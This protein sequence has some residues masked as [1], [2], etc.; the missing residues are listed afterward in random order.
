MATVRTPIPPP[1]RDVWRA[2]RVARYARALELRGSGFTYQR[3]GM[4]LGV[5]AARAQQMF[6]VGLSVSD[7]KHLP[8]PQ[9]E[10]LRELASAIADT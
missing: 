1:D 2:R 4:R 10:H 7:L 5:G 6:A 8:A 3:I 9:R